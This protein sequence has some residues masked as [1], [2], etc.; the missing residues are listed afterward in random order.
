MNP[1]PSICSPGL[2]DTDTDMT[3]PVW[4]LTVAEYLA[5]RGWGEV[6][7]VET[8]CGVPP[9]AEKSAIRLPSM[10][11]VVFQRTA[12]TILLLHLADTWV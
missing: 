9:Q 5:I 10:M 4:T 3:L 1:P 7:A 12:I 11:I 6:E 2:Q 8:D